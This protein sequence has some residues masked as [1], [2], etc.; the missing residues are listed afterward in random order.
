MEREIA[1]PREHETVIAH[2]GDEILFM[3]KL[4]RMGVVR[5]AVKR[6]FQKKTKNT[7]LQFCSMTP[8]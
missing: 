5:G 6:H 2:L 4:K 7:H 1:T 8:N 3:R